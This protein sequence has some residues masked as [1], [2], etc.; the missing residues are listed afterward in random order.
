MISIMLRR[1]A[2]TL[3]RSPTA[4]GA[5]FRRVCARRGAAKAV[6][7]TA[8]K[9][10]KIIYRLL[11]FGQPYVET[12]QQLYEEKYRARL[13]KHLQKSADALGFQLLPKQPST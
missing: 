11:K 12:G 6:T 13:L 4:L 10:A 9:L 5:F 3:H 1:A 2:A 7:A 8:H